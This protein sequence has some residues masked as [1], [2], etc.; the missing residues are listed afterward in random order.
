MVMTLHITAK[1]VVPANMDEEMK[2]A[3]FTTYTSM[4]TFYSDSTYLSTSVVPSPTN[5]TGNTSDLINI[6][7]TSGP[8]I[9]AINDEYFSTVLLPSFIY[10]CVLLAVGIPGN[11]LVVY[12]YGFKSKRTVSRTFILTL[13][14]LDLINCL[15]S[16]STELVILRNF[17]KFNYPT[18]CKI[19]RFVTSFCNHSTTIIL[20]S[21]AIDRFRKIRYPLKKKMKMSTAKII[22]ICSM[23]FGC[24]T[25]IPFVL[26]YGTK[27]QFLREVETDTQRLVYQGKLCLP[28]DGLDIIYQE[29][30]L[31]VLS[32]AHVLS[33]VILGVLYSFV[34]KSVLLSHNSF[35]RVDPASVKPHSERKRSI[36]LGRRNTLRLN[37][38]SSAPGTAGRTNTM[39]FL[40]T[41]VFILSFMPYLVLAFL[42]TFQIEAKQTSTTEKAVRHFF[43]RS[44]F[45]NSAINPILYCFV[46]KHFRQEAITGVHRMVPGRKS[47]YTIQR[48]TARQNVRKS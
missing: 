13:A 36:E 15:F 31:I 46:S 35:R 33:D 42:R 10:A 29:V 32:F 21:I 43:L 2:N 1:A 28:R 19:S 47:Q 24:L 14:V 40:V 3:T 7:I 17:L 30:L 41:L 6:Y 26:F 44:Y 48:Q 34:G 22:V 16:I 4:D 5:V 27:T 39:L 20:L 37:S 45:L 38:T 8:Y 12:V 23:L 9:D 11:G 18:I 25:G